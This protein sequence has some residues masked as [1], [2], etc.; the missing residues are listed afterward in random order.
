MPKDY[1]TYDQLETICSN[2]E[3]QETVVTYLRKEDRMKIYTSDNTTLTELKK[4]LRENP[5]DWKCYEAGRNSNGEV[6]GYFFEAPKDLLT[7]RTKKATRKLT[8]EQRAQLSERM[9]AI[10]SSN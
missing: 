9:K 2:I 4:R 8:D 6:T 1:L 7:F 5:E 10:H 3:E